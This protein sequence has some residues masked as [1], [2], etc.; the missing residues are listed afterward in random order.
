MWLTLNKPLVVFDLETTGVDIAKDRIVQI[1][2]VKIMPDGTQDSR[3]TLVNP[4]IPIPAEASAV[5]NITDEAVR[6][7]PRFSQIAKSIHAW[8]TGCDYAGYNIINF[9]IPMLNEEFLRC[10][11]ELPQ[12]AFIDSYN[13]FRKKEERTLSAAVKFY[14]N[15]EL[16]NAH[17]AMA[18]V[19]ASFKVLTAQCDR[20]DDL[21]TDAAELAAYTQMS[22]VVDY[23]GWF[24]KDADGDYIY[25]RGKAK[26]TKVHKDPGFAQWML[27]QNFLTLDTQRWTN[28]ILQ[29]GKG[30]LTL[31]L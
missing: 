5:H 23:A 8:L 21:P 12:G 27:R 30:V 7:F 16:T 14:C 9:D 19:L 17:D 26:G 25:N 31:A 20:Y 18:D 22:E 1:A 11:L 3:Q 15:E 4:G 6:D 10:N 2:M 28:K 13:I 24:T 29:F